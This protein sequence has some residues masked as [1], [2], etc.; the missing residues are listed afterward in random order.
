MNDAC[1]HRWLIRVIMT[2]D[3][4]IHSK[5]IREVLTGFATC[6][7]D[8]YTLMSALL[9]IH[10]YFSDFSREFR[11]WKSWSLYRFCHRG[12]TGWLGLKYTTCKSSEDFIVT[13][14]LSDALFHSDIIFI[15]KMVL[16]Q[17]LV[18]VLFSWLQNTIQ[19]KLDPQKFC[20][21]SINRCARSSSPFGTS[22]VHSFHTVNVKSIRHTSAIMY[23]KFS[24]FV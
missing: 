14:K 20:G 6:S 8:N 21:H 16:V 4:C 10:S 2:I 19:N 3:R 1:L 24:Q 15:T 17:E 12:N 11:I 18:F 9:T 5:N 7:E 13:N 23:H 22:T